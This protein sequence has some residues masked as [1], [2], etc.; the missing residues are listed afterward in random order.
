MDTITLSGLQFRGRHGYHEW[1]RTEGNHFEVDLIF[2]LDLLKAAT[3][4]ELDHTVDYQIA[5]RIVKDVMLGPSVKLIET[6][7]QRIG[8]QLFQTFQQVQSLEVRV[9]KMNPPL[10]TP[11][12]YSE[13]TRLWQR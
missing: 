7:A 1:E 6:L 13:V 9:R 4:D 2:Q 12:R 11:T 8:E 10:E 3:T 5:E